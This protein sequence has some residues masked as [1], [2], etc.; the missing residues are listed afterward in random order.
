MVF[1]FIHGLLYPYARRG[2]LQDFQASAGAESLEENGGERI[3]VM[4]K[5]RDHRQLSGEGLVGN[6]L[7][8]SPPSPRPHPS[9]F[10]LKRSS[11]RA[12]MVNSSL[13]RRFSTRHSILTATWSR[14]QRRVKRSF[15]AGW[16][17]SR[18]QCTKVAPL[19]RSWVAPLARSL[20]EADYLI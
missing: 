20:T 7:L 6:Q 3:G 10:L 16:F 9:P 14:V 13:K 17:T 5:R 12:Y 19:C 11:P 8:V 4:R 18:I 15:F 1:D 2:K